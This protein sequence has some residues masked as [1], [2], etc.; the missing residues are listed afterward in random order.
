M[1]V[2]GIIGS[3]NIGGQVARRAVATGHEVVI[4]N[5]RSPQ[6]L[7][8]L[9]EELGPRARSADVAEA[10]RAGE[11][12][13][14]AIPIDKYPQLPANAFVGKVVLDAG[15]YYPDWNGRIAALEDESTTTA[16]LLQ[17]HLPGATVVKAFSDIAAADITTDGRPAGSA[18][19]RALI[20]AGDDEAAKARVTQLIED[21]GFDVVDAGAL[22]EG[23][24][25]QRDTPAYGARLDAH[26]ARRALSEARRYRDL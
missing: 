22:S 13:L 18:G 8:G 10:A 5:S 3:G 4:A 20:I 9:V 26:G 7:A 16:E 24:R 12:V 1:T 21:F 14:V 25:Y 2:I 23:W 17:A 11:L 6:T 19:R 15:N